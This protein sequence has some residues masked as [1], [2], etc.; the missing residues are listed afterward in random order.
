MN[1]EHHHKILAFLGSTQPV[2]LLIGKQASDRASLLTKIIGHSRNTHHIIRLQGSEGVSPHK[3]TQLLSTQWS[4][5]IKDPEARL[6]TQL[7]EILKSLSMRN[8]S[9]LLIIDD[10]HHLPFAVIAALMHL[11]TLQNSAMKMNLHL[12]LSGQQVLQ[13]KITSLLVQP[14]PFIN[15]DDQDKTDLL[16][17]D[18][19]ANSNEPIQSNEYLDGPSSNWI[20]ALQNNKIRSFSVVALIGIGIVMWLSQPMSARVETRPVPLATNQRPA[21]PVAPAAPQPIPNANTVI[22]DHPQSPAP[23]APQTPALATTQPAAPQPMAAQPMAS[24]PKPQ[25]TWVATKPTPKSPVKSAT[26]PHGYT[27]QVMS[28]NRLASLQSYIDKNKFNKQL[29]IIKI[30]RNNK[31][32]YIMVYGN[33]A[34]HEQAEKAK[35]N[36]NPTLKSLKP[37][38]K[39][40]G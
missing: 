7:E 23:I 19:S 36:L 20:H 10:A 22:N 14:A 33:Y 38:I 18:K 25:P 5:P 24:Q 21:T 35:I 26:K 3:L 12:I 30:E 28:G 8:K 2:M 4:T 40:L 6:E 31:D 13:H 11:T 37:W 29:R 9:C 39:K 27:L 32:W 16:L 1:P 17:Q 15:L 34:T